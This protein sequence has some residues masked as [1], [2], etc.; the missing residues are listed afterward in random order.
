MENLSPEI[1]IIT[2]QFLTLKDS[3]NL[4]LVCK[5]QYNLVIKLHYNEIF[6]L[7]G[8]QLDNFDLKINRRLKTLIKEWKFIE[9]N[10]KQLINRYLKLELKYFILSYLCFEKKEKEYYITLLEFAGD[11]LNNFKFVDKN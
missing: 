5:Q 2:F 9:K 4:F 8:Y 7:K 1:L 3:K 10:S 6:F 11:N